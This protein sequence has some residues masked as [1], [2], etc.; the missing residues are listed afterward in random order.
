MQVCYIISDINKALAFEWIAAA[1]Q[2]NLDI[3][4][5]ILNSDDSELER[6]LNIKGVPVVRVKCRGKR[7]W[8]G[9]FCLLLRQL[10]KWNPEVVH[11]HLLQ[12]SILG[13][14]ASWFAGCRKRIVTRHHGD[15]HH[16]HHK[17][18]VLWDKLCNVLATDIIAISGNVKL[19]L[20]EMDHAPAEKIH[21]IS[22][23]FNWK[24]F[25]NIEASQVNNLK[26]K[27]D[28]LGKSPVIGCIAR[29]IELKGIQYIIPAFKQFL[30]LNPNAVLVLANSQG[31]YASQLGEL[32][33][34]LPSESYRLISF[35][36][37]V[38]EL[39]QCF[40][41]FVHVPVDS[42]AEAFGQVYVEALAAEV[43]SIFT[44]SGIASDFIEHEQNSWV[45]P[46]RDSTAIEHALK[47]LWQTPELRSR[48]KRNG[49]NSVEE[50]FS[51][52]QM[53]LKLEA[54]YGI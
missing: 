5:I 23:G 46:Y 49:W 25:R 14:T 1:F 40:D 3:R 26:C 32:L 6:F 19:I 12:A 53:I 2:D 48:L 42:T 27:Y 36:P 31:D 45:V 52:S 4:F 13:L 21:V 47:V 38:E 39:Y 20:T 10:R 18:G 7:D 37:A 41:L 24:T 44:I 22:H 30:Q 9:A 15:L 17:K 28:L 51:F 8:L 16:R 34:S 43:P 33:R 11:C 54:L 29:F 35:E 50:R